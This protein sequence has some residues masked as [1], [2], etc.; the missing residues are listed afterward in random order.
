MDKNT[1][2]EI[3][4]GRKGQGVVGTIFWVGENKYGSGKRFGV[5]GEDGETYWVPE[6]HVKASDTSP[7]PALDES[8]IPNRGDCV[9]F[10]KGGEAFAGEV[11]WVGQNK[12]GPGHRVGVKDDMGETHWL[13]ARHVTPASKSDLPL[14]EPRR[15]VSE[16]DDDEP[17]PWRESAPLIPEPPAWLNDDSPV[18]EPPP[19]FEESEDLGG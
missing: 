6:E 3:V 19:W 17:A 12:S 11:F 15:H 10:N 9:S 7:P 4:G 16:P 2:V 1:R 18:E 14:E 5:H 8:Q 13:D